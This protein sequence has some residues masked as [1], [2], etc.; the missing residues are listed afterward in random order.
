MAE[1]PY[2]TLRNID[3]RTRVWRRALARY[4]RHPYSIEPQG[5]ALL[6]IDMQRYFTSPESHAYLPA[7]EAI[8]PRLLALVG[9]FRRRGAPVIFTRHAHRRGDEGLMGVWWRE[10]IYDT[11]PLSEL[12]P[13][14]ESR[15]S[16]VVRKTRYSAFFGTGLER[17]LR[18]LGVGTVCVSGVMTHLCCETT[19][20]DAFMRDFQV[21]FLMDATATE[22]EALHLSSLRTLA[23]GFAEVL[24]CEELMERL[25]WTGRGRRTGGG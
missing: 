25:G 1:R 18:R 24:S 19:A 16:P 10:C 9:E 17:R 12:D 14:L 13:R 15:G 2:V 4:S 5:A 20:R 8:L 3:E 11:D 21:V 7:S 23:D 6:V 22:D